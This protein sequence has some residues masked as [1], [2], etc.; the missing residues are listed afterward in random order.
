MDLACGRLYVG[1]Y[2]FR[3]VATT[4]EAGLNAT[5]R[6]IRSCS[7]VSAAC[8]DQTINHT[9]HRATVNEDDDMP[10]ETVLAIAWDWRHGCMY[11][12]AVEKSPPGTCPAAASGGH[13]ILVPS[14]RSETR[15][16]SHNDGHPDELKR[17]P[18]PR[19]CLPAEPKA[20]P[21]ARGTCRPK[22]VRLLGS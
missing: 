11:P 1:R 13:I 3:P 7:R 17:W 15:R 12:S 2:R 16:R 19:P 10:R 5:L 18:A 21:A 20:I 22:F 4:D 9:G 6:R 14:L 8:R